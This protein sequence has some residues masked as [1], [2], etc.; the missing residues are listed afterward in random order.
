MQS[1]DSSVLFTFGSFSVHYYGLT[2]FLAIITALFVMR[3][4]IKKYYKE[5]NTEILLDILPA[6]ILFSIIGARAY[7]VI[8]DFSYYSKHL[9][10]IV[11]VWNGGLSIHGGIIGGILSGLILSK[12][13]K[14]NFLQYADVFSYGLVI[15]QAVGRFGNYFNCEAFGKPC[16]LPYIGLFIPKQYRPTGFEDFD[17]FHPTFLYE[18]IWNVIVF[19]IL[20]FVIR[21]VPKIRQGTIF[22]SYLILYSI[23]R[24]FIEWCRLDSVLNIAGVPIAQIVSVLTIFIASAILLFIYKKKSK[25]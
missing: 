17:Y 3:F 19:L 21:K 7:Y 2:M 18:S 25:N 9:S 22:F 23:G 12:I 13:K 8:M 15:G 24:M 16:S 5:I 14:I 11:A 4:M 1:P 6:V 10:E 20:F